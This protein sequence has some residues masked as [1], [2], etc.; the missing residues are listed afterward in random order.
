[1]LAF[2]KSVHRKDNVDPNSATEGD[3]NMNAD[4]KQDVDPCNDRRIT[5]FVDQGEKDQI[6]PSQVE[7][8]EK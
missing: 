3:I 1:M 2:G 6:R 7:S 8:I 4:K 5:N